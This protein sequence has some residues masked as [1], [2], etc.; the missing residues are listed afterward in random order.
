MRQA[1]ICEPL[2]TP[3][4]RYGGVLRDVPATELAS[5]VI[6]EVVKRTGLAPELIDDVQLGQGYPSGEAPC[7]GR[8]AALDAGLP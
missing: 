2:R 5:L 4:G 1:V 8:I 3:I 7:I 6:R